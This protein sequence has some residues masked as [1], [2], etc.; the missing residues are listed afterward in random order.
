MPPNLCDY[1]ITGINNPTFL[2]PLP[3]LEWV[4]YWNVWSKLLH[5]VE[6][7]NI[8]LKFTAHFTS[9]WAARFGSW[10]LN[11]S[12]RIQRRIQIT[13]N[14]SKWDV[15]QTSAPCITV[16]RFVVFS[17]YLSMSC[18]DT[19]ASE[20]WLICFCTPNFAFPIFNALLGI[21]EQYLWKLRVGF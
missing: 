14:F 12:Y 19:R 2:A 7:Y 15:R 9:W 11:Y 1:M 18:I 10:L 4:N 21:P 20:H 13:I 6:S 8:M 16:M 17:T 5:R 3:F